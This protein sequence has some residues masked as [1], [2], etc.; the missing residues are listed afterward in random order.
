M[1]IGVIGA[2]GMAGREI[3]HEAVRRGETAVAIVRDGARATELLG[4]D[5]EVLAKDA[6]ELTSHDL[7]PFDAI[8]NAFAIAPDEAH[9]HVDLARHLVAAV[10]SSPGHSP[11]LLFILGAGSLT[12][13]GTGLLAIEDIRRLPGS[14]A[15]VNIPAQQLKELEYLRTV[16][17]VD[18][19]GVSPQF[20]F[21]PGAATTPLVGGDGLLTAADGGSHTTAG[22]M[23]VA[24]LD[25]LQTPTHHKTRFTVSDA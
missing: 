3:Y 8:V 17:T 7:A 18:W 6:F 16:D 24:V 15:W 12:N 9:R 19:V 22:T 23:A 2:T 21:L 20:E 25:E 11:R 4:A 14:E 1:R 13:P 5:A 10:S